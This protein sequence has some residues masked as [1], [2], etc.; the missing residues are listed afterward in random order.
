[1][2]VT[3]PLRDFAEEVVA[4]LRQAGYEALLAG[5]CVRDLQ[6]GLEPKDYDVATNAIPAE[7]R[8]VFGHRKT[9]AVGES[10]GVVVVLGP[11]VQHG[12]V[13][14]ATFRTDGSYSDG[15]RPDNVTYATAQEDAMRRD[16]TIN[17]MFFDPATNQ[18]IDYVG[19]LQDLQDRVL[20]AIGDPVARIREDKLRMLRAIRFAA[21]FELTVDQSTW[22]G[23]VQ[24]ADELQQV[25]PERITMELR[26]MLRHPNRAAA[27]RMLYS[28]GLLN[29][30]L[31]ELNSVGTS[32]PIDRTCRQLEL[33]QIH[34]FE[35][36]MF[37]VLINGMQ[38]Q[39]ISTTVEQRCREL[40]MS[41]AE[42]EQIVW[43]CTAKDQLNGAADLPKH[44]L[45]TLLHHTHSDYLLEWVR[46]RALEQGQQPA[47]YEFC[48][49]YLSKT[50]AEQ[51]WPE[52]FLKGHDLI[53]MGL[54]P[55]REFSHLLQRVFE[56]QLDEQLATKDQAIELVRKLIS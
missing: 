37:I 13:E 21:R 33:I 28:S 23:I 6:L 16:Y 1:M 51:L 10:F 56:A 18:V 12:Q 7:V 54:K 52:P 45:K 2:L 29:Q 30:I 47:D 43:L 22:E 53:E 3:T 34:S 26:S 11:T 32:L 24:H 20:R 17:G 49:S 48:R 38:E 41:N 36:A 14:V 46:V 39:D 19:G 35:L 5:G 42:T 25:S 31:M 50:S 27:F 4:R 9:L 40:R 44:Q 55:G 15:R 8:A